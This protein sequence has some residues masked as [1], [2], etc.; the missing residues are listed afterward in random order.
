MQN[1]IGLFLFKCNTTITKY[2]HYLQG[3]NKAA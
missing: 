3:V 2:I 1:L